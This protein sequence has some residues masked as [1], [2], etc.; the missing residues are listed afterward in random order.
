[1]RHWASG[2]TV[3]TATHPADQTPRGMTVS[4]FNSVS[5]EL[6]LIAVFLK[7]TTQT[8]DAVL[9]SQAFGVAIL[10]QDQ[11]HLS[12]RFAGFDPAYPDH[13]ANFT[14]LTVQYGDTGAPMLA[15]TLGWVECKVWAIYDGSTHHV[16]LGEVV[17]TSTSE[18]FSIQPLVYYN[19]GY[20]S[21]VDG[22]E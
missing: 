1:M 2:V 10:R 4:T 22:V 17:N 21:L 14:D 19:R 20:H 7:K 16:V 3:V 11:A 8:A 18:D 15:A 9:A 12:A 6:P 5:L 13:E